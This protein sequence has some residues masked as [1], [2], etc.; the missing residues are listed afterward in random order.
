[1][2][3]QSVTTLLAQC[4]TANN[5]VKPLYIFPD[6]HFVLPWSFRLLGKF[7]GLVLQ[8]ACGFPRE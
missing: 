5:K 3:L 4:D 6:W 1:M 2:L 8:N 7:G